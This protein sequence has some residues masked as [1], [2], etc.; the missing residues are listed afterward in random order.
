MWSEDTIDRYKAIRATHFAM[1]PFR[2]FNHV[3]DKDVYIKLYVT[4]RHCVC[5]FKI[6]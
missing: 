2:Y 6:I 3:T 5:T 4:K 1:P